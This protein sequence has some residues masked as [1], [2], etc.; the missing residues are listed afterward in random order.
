MVKSPTSQERVKPFAQ[1][2]EKRYT[3]A[4]KKM[5]NK[6]IKKIFQA[7]QNHFNS[8]EPIKPAQTPTLTFHNPPQPCPAFQSLHNPPQPSK[9]LHN[10]SEPFKTFH[11]PS[12]SS[13]T[14]HNLLQPST[15]SHNLPQPSTTLHNLPQPSPILKTLLKPTFS[16]FLPGQTW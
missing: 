14:F 3:N 12:Q 8:S 9:I 6:T 16:P 10:L 13:T 4:N 11:N 7:T 1:N 15:T 5:R 2:A